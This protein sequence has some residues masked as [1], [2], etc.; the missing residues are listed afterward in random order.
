MLKSVLKLCIRSFAFLKRLCI[1]IQN[2]IAI[3]CNS[4]ELSSTI[5]LNGPIYISNKG[6]MLFGHNVKFNSTIDANPITQRRCVLYTTKNGTLTIGDNTGMSGCTIYCTN[7][8]SIGKDVLI[9]A[10]T[11]IYDTDFHS[12]S[13]KDRLD[14]DT[15]IKNEPVIIDD[16]CFIGANV[17]ILKGVKIGKGSIIAAG[18][19]VTKNV[20]ENELWGGNPASL[21]RNNINV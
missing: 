20:G 5:I 8:I 10:G 4:V 9:G 21:I 17:T 3:I 2:N 11:N 7:K 18:S 12:L 15:K 13:L 19:V 16:Y 6:Q 1:T 14:G